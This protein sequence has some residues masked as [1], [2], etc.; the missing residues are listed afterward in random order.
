[1][2]SFEAT[3]AFNVVLS[4]KRFFVFHGATMAV[5]YSLS[6]YGSEFTLDDV[7][8]VTEVPKKSV[9]NWIERDIF[10]PFVDTFT[11]GGGKRLFAP[12]DVIQIQ[13]LGDLTI[14]TGMAPGTA[15]AVL[16]IV[17]R[18]AQELA[19]KNRLGEDIRNGYRDRQY[20]YLGFYGG[21]LSYE[22][23]K[24]SQLPDVDWSIA[25]ILLPVDAIVFRVWN[26]LYE[27]RADEARAF[28]AQTPDQLKVRFAD[29]SLALDALKN[30]S[31]SR[32]LSEDERAKMH[33]LGMELVRIKKA[34]GVLD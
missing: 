24:H 5:E 3:L 18:R 33:V 32:D 19:D 9:R 28:E 30:E 2:A 20:L 6:L 23:Y 11:A 12:I 13:A 25:G 15:R 34:L 1:M 14:L 21:K 4:H 7:E 16:P 29:T 22:F 31:E 26:A 17:Y 27:L 10:Q 8:K